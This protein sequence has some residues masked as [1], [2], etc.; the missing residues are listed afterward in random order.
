MVK[1]LKTDFHGSETDLIDGNDFALPIEV[2][3]KLN[4][5]A[6]KNDGYGYS[7]N[8]IPMVSELPIKMSIRLLKKDKF[9]SLVTNSSSNN[10]ILLY[11]AENGLRV[12]IEEEILDLI[13]KSIL[14]WNKLLVLY[15]V[16]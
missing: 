4:I 5:Y 1:Y 16:S 15:G 13:E 10:P 8:S 12:I 9:V 6:L 14:D 2:E 3:N 7:F 11:F